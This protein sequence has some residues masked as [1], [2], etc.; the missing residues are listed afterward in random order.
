MIRLF[1]F[2]PALLSTTYIGGGDVG[3]QAMGDGPRLKGR[4][5]LVIAA[6]AG[7]P[8]TAYHT[9]ARDLGE[10]GVRNVRVR[11]GRSS[12]RLGIK[13]RGSRQMPAYDVLGMIEAGG[14]LILPG[15]RFK[16]GDGDGVA[17]WVRDLS[18][19]GPPQSREPKGVFGLTKSQFDRVFKDLGR[20]VDFS[21]EGETPAA[22]IDKIAAK[23]QVPLSIEP[24][25]KATLARDRLAEELAG[26][27]SGT[28]LGYVL[29]PLGLG[30]VPC[31]AQG[32]RLRYVVLPLEAEPAA[33][34][35]KDKAMKYWPVGWA[36][37][38]SKHEVLPALFKFHN[39][40]IQDVSLGKVIEEVGK[41]LKAP[42]LF[43]RAA[44]A[45]H[46]VDMEKTDVTLPAKR[47]TYGL[48][49]NRAL[50][51]AKLKY[52]LRVD[53]KGKP[54]LWVTTVKPA[55]AAKR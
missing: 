38:G 24:R 40:S 47:T 5:S 32:Q 35:G 44:L 55:F 45:R 31:E 36:P 50:F 39:V 27:S 52:A 13:S 26:F 8:I 11:G 2:I 34:A 14:D 41:R 21:T 15:A 51:K 1:L 10:A 12:D 23:L 18:E 17:R 16:P 53:E 33:G 6:E 54:F 22:V 29:R 37:S 43:D 30:F 42:V 48:V 25:L 9:W 19:R 4:V 7:T 49:L 28:V 3:R 46:G 20:T